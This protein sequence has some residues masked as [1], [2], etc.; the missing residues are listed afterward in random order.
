MTTPAPAAPQQRPGIFGG[1]MGGLAGLA[2]GGLIGSMLFGGLGGGFGGG[3][4][5][6]EIVLIGGAAYL[7]FRM[8]RGRQA[9][10]PEP[11]YAGAGGSSAYGAGGPSW[12]AGGSAATLDAPPSVSDLDRGLG[13]IRAMDPSFDPDAFAEWAKAA[14]VD[15]Q[16][17]VARRDLSGVQDRLTPQ[18]FGRLQAQC[19]QLRGARRTNRI[20][21]VQIG[22]AQVTEAWQETGQDWITVSFA[23]SLVDYIVDDTS[24]AIVEGST[25]P[26]SIEEYW[27]FTR[28]V[29]PKSWRLSAIQTA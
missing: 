15:V 16:G 18:E 8:L 2:L 6:L 23:V 12:Q 4:G 13:H 20:E 1:L 24:G 19:D 25:T 11:A 9:S 29:G 17:A 10:Q 14:F 5:L 7:L 27:T 3:V 22:R 21:R 26:E 28:P